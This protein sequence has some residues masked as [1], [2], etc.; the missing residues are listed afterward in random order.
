MK[1]FTRT[2]AFSNGLVVLSVVLALSAAFQFPGWDSFGGQGD[3]KLSLFLFLSALFFTALLLG[4]LARFIA[5][6]ARED[7]KSLEQ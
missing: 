7:L 5:K 1:Y 6:D 2:K 3:A 4:F